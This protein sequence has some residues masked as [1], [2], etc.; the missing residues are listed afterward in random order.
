MRKQAMPAPV[1]RCRYSWEH[2]LTRKYGKSD[3][4]YPR[5]LLHGEASICSCDEGRRTS[6][7]PRQYAGFPLYATRVAI[8]PLSA[9]PFIA[10]LAYNDCLARTRMKSGQCWIYL[11]SFLL[12]HHML[13]PTTRMIHRMWKD[14][15]PWHSIPY[16]YRPTHRGSCGNTQRRVSLQR[17]RDRA[18]IVDQLRPISNCVLNA[19]WYSTARRI[20][21]A[22]RHSLDLQSRRFD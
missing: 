7:I 20:V 18:I 3:P 5:S 14:R 2:K 22:R 12:D 17:R 16:F 13:G 9:V 11:A 6:K 21:R 8:P 1:E 10:V 4:I 15:R 19:A